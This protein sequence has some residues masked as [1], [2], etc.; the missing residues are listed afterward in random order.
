[1]S[2]HVV[3]GV[4][5]LLIIG[6]VAGYF[7]YT[8]YLP[9]TLVF[10]ITDPPGGGQSQYPS[11]ITHIIITYTS[12]DI[13]ASGAVNST[14]AGWHTIVASGTV[15]L[16]TVLN[17][18]QTLATTRPPTGRY[19]MVRMMAS[20]AMVTVNGVQHAYIVPSGKIQV[21]ITGGGFQ[22][23]DQQTVTVLFTLSFNSSEIL[24][25]GPNLNPVAK[26]EVTTP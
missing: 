26:A 2:K 20:T 17:A 13:H 11:S 7:L 15:D 16:M 8:D 21:L 1:M 9:G 5:V 23:T 25:M 10:R 6:G 19:D 24:A 18:Q 12:I 4:L 3:A 14:N 22:I